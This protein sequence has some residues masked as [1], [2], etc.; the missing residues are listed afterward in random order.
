M[1]VQN[2]DGSWSRAYAPDGTPIVGGDWFGEPE[3]GARTARSAVVPYLLAVAAR[4]DPD[5]KFRAA[6]LR[7]GRFVLRR[8]VAPA[9]FRGGTLDNPN[10][11]DKEAAF[12][13]MRAL[14]ALSH[15]DALEGFLSG[16][17]AAAW[18]AVS[19]HS[20][21]PVPTLADTP[22]GSAKVRSV[23]W[24]GINSVWG[25]GVSD[26]YSLFFAG[27]LVRW[28]PRRKFR[29]SGE[30]PSSSPGRRSNSSRAPASFMALP[31]QECSRRGFPSAARGR[32]TV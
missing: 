9:E 26:I 14:F 25:V 4:G 15:Y 21:W 31:V 23:G 16:A 7:A 8:Q 30:L 29:S 12:L 24:G 20:F 3:D 27:D 11:V 28:A 10:V 17:V 1:R 2:S 19:W 22:V 6:A 13:A 18:A 5:G 32:M